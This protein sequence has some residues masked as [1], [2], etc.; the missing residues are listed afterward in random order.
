MPTTVKAFS[1][2]VEAYAATGQLA[3]AGDVA[4]LLLERGQDDPSVNNV[5]IGFA[6]ALQAEYKLASAAMIEAQ[7]STD[8]SLRIAAEPRLNAVKELAVKLLLRWP[9][10]R[11]IRRRT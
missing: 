4:G 10:E 5:L 11:A 2:A 8:L 7:A 3:A 6:Q 9:G 1:A